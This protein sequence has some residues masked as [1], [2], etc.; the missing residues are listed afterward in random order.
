MAVVSIKLCAGMV[1]SVLL[2]ALV[3]L[4][5]PISS[6]EPQPTA[7]DDAAS[8]L[9]TPPL[10]ALRGRSRQRYFPAEPTTEPTTEPPN[11]PPA[12]P[13]STPNPTTAEPPST[14]NPTT[15]EPPS[16]P[17]PTPADTEAAAVSPPTAPHSVESTPP[18]AAA[19]GADDDGWQNQGGTPW[20]LRDVPMTPEFPMTK[21]EV[22]RSRTDA[23]GGGGPRRATTC[24]ME[25]PLYVMVVNR[26]VDA[27]ALARA[28]GKV[29]VLA[30]QNATHDV[31]VRVQAVFL[32]NTGCSRK[33]RVTRPENHFESHA[34]DL[35][36]KLDCDEWADTVAQLKRDVGLEVI[37]PTV[38]LAFG[39]SQ[40]AMQQDALE[41]RGVPR[42]M[43]AHSDAQLREPRTLERLATITA[44]FRHSPFCVLFSHYDIIAVFDV[45]STARHVGDWDPYLWY[46][47]DVDY[48]DRCRHA[49]LPCG[50][51]GGDD[52]IHAGK[53]STTRHAASEQGDKLRKRMDT[54][55][56]MFN[57]YR[58]ARVDAF[59][60]GRIDLPPPG[61]KV[62][63]C[64]LSYNDLAR[65]RSSQEQVAAVSASMRR[66]MMPWRFLMQRVDDDSASGRAVIKVV[67]QYLPVD[68]KR[69]DA[70]KQAEGDV[71][72]AIMKA[73][74]ADQATLRRP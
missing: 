65:A 57:S 26:M 46:H 8:P 31:R 21:C 64:D 6:P 47:S 10:S 49:Q 4:A 70:P 34:E 24:Y 5:M 59:G 68:L 33:L 36:A 58:Q 44:L 73:T 56:S 53:G 9:V 22:D 41:K 48:Y 63:G 19:A 28:A 3:L 74:G 55:G 35:S 54:Q 20:A 39:P 62:L 67:F 25:V 43:W 72:A 61:G 30:L 69:E 52:V 2:V 37:V 38:P 32:D 42:M 1:M 66:W 27:V 18:P 71:Q 51:L 15:A 7:T 17:N 29:N 45:Y 40:N 50:E 12:E 11:L 60:T 16:T 23:S 14:P 13:P